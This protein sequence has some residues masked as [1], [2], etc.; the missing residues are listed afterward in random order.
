MTDGFDVRLDAGVLRLTMDRPEHLNAMT[1]EMADRA[2]EELEGAAARDDVRVVLLTGTG[3][4]F[5]SGADLS[6]ADAHE[7]FDVTALDRANRIILE[8]GLGWSTPPAD[9]EVVP[10]PVPAPS[11]KAR[12]SRRASA[13][14]RRWPA[15]SPSPRSRRCSSSRSRASG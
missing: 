5:S 8:A 10:A 12:A 4:A 2:A 3:D 13:A 7:N 15:T 14:P 9:A 11:G 1:A 6:G